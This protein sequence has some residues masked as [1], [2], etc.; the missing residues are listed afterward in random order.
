MSTESTGRAGGNTPVNLDTQY[1]SGSKKEIT[2]K[3]INNCTGKS[4]NILVRAFNQI[5]T[6]VEKGAKIIDSNVQELIDAINPKQA[7]AIKTIYRDT[8]HNPPQK[9]VSNDDVRR[10][11]TKK[12]GLNGNYIIFCDLNLYGFN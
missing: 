11:K 2:M 3:D 5:M 8:I 6:W 12:V 4:H 1:S 7:I 10:A 9:Y